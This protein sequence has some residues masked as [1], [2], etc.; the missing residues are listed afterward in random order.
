MGQIEEI[1]DRLVALGFEVEAIAAGREERLSRR[2]LDRRLVYA[3]E[4]AKL[5]E[6]VKSDVRLARNPEIAAQFAARISQMRVQMGRMQVKWR[7]PE[8]EADPAGYLGEIRE[9]NRY[10]AALRDWGKTALASIG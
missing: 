3:K 10:I 4:N 2:I 7:I 6:A 1:L 5:L 8:V 9:I